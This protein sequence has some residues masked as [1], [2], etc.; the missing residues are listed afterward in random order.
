MQFLFCCLPL[1]VLFIHGASISSSQIGGLELP[2]SWCLRQQLTS[3]RLHPNSQSLFVRDSRHPSNL[4][5]GSKTQ[6][7]FCCPP[8]RD[9]LL[10]IHGAY[11]SSSQVGG[12]TQNVSPSLCVTAATLPNWV[13]C[14]KRCSHFAG[15]SYCDCLL[16]IHGAYVSSSQIGG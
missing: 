2:Q 10:S 3:W 1:L 14:P 15:S 4:G 11:V 7:P 8:F 12:C 5:G 16:S 13:L 6:F 9:C